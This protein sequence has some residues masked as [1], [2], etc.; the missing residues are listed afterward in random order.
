MKLEAKVENINIGNHY[1]NCTVITEDKKQYNLKMTQ[2]QSDRIK[3]E[4]LY[5]FKVREEILEDKVNYHIESFIDIVESTEDIELLKEKLVKFYPT[6]K[7][8]ISEIKKSI[9]SY[10]DEIKNPILN[11]IT[12]NIYNKHKKK[13]YLYPA[14]VRF[15]HAYI[16]G[17]SQHTKTMLELASALLKVYDF[18]NKDLV[19]SAVI[20][21]DMCKVVE[22]SGV[23][24]SEY[25]KEGQL[26]GHLVMITHEIIKEAV[27]LGYDQS[28]EVLVLNHILLSHHGLP[29]FGAAKRPQTAEALLVW[30]IDT[31]DSKFEVI[32]Q[33][34]DKI[35]ENNFT[36]TIAV[37]DKTKYYKHKV[38]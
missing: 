6:C 19:Y 11:E 23:E 7:T 31:I 38:K 33:E 9:E 35:E 3:L 21:H 14:A 30:Y 18:V 2:E 17:L 4:K 29:N 27:R 25:T 37:A 34:L 32:K 13:F 12:K 10:L 1:F 8:P 16:G 22:L 15:H 28:E 5:L 36:P 20:L 24:A 26:I